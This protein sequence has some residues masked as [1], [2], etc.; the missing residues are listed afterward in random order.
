[1]SDAADTIADALFDMPDTLSSTHAAGFILARLNDAGW[2]MTR[3]QP[4]AHSP[5]DVCGKLAA[6]AY[7]TG[8]PATNVVK[9]DLLNRLFYGNERGP[10]QTPCPV[11]EGRWSGIQFGWP[12]QEWEHVKTRER[13]PVEVDPKLQELYDQGCRCWQ[14]KGSQATTGWQPDEHCGCVEDEDA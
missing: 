5:S 12:G 9:S 13:R 6:W 4:T 7:A 3:R 10:S 1:M 14:H 11:H 2:Q 8:Q